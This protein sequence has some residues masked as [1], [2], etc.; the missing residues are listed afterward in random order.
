HRPHCITFRAPVSDLEWSWLAAPYFGCAAVILAVAL[1]VALIRGDRVLRLGMIGASTT[2]LPW[3]LCQALA[4]C[5]NDAAVATRLL[6]LVWLAVGLWIVRR[7]SPSGERRRSLRLVLGV[8]VC[9]AIGSLDTFL[10]YGVWGVYPIAWLPSSVAAG[11][12]LY[13]VLRTDLLRPQGF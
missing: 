1:A 10:L 2:A 12:G 6:R 11:I 8:L 4:A 13:V 5:T 9:G 3:A 7:S